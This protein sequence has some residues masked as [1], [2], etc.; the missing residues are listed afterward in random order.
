MAGGVGLS[1]VEI[2][3]QGATAWRYGPELPFNIWLGAMVEDPLGK[4]T[5]LTK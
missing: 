1:S 3:D 4:L 5:K 2:L